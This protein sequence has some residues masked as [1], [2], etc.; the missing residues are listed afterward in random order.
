MKPEKS[1]EFHLLRPVFL[2]LLLCCPTWNFPLGNLGRFPQ[3][4]PAATVMLHNLNHW[5]S[6]CF[7]VTILM[8][9]RPTLLLQIDMGSLTC[10]L[11]RVHTVHTKVSQAPTSLHKS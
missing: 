11:I 3:G 10:A 1:L 5:P 7:C 4:K 2:F 6:V 8:T 9:V